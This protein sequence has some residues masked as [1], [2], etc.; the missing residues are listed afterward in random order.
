MIVSHKW[1]QTYFDKKLPEVEKLEEVLTLSA[2]EIENVKKVGDDYILDI[3]VLPNRAHD[4]LAH[5]GVARELAVLLE[6]DITFPNKELPEITKG[7]SISI[8]NEEQ[9]LCRRYVG[10]KVEGV[11]IG[12]SPDWLKERLETIGQKSINNIVDATNYVMFDIGQPLH[13]FDVDKV[14]GG[15]VVR[16]ARMGEKITTLDGNE[17]ELDESVLVIADEKDSLAIAGV[18]GGKKAEVDENTKNIILEAANF[19]PVNVRKTSRR[20]NILTDSSKRFENEITPELARQAMEKVTALISEIA[21]GGD[22]KI[23]E[24]V[25]VYPRKANQYKAGVSLDEINR[26]L[27]TQITKKEVENIWGRFEFDVE[28]IVPIEKIKKIINSEMVLDKKYESGAS[29]TYGAPLVFD[30]SS[31]SAW[32][33]KEAGIAIPRISVDQFVFSE[34]IKKDNLK[35]GDLVFSNTG[36][37]IKTGIYK[38]SVEFLPG[39][40][41]ESGVDHL[42]IYIGEGKILHTSSQTEKVVIEDLDEAKMFKNIVGYGRI[43]G[44]DKERFVVAIPDERLDLRIKEDLIEEIGR[45][46]GYKNIESKALEVAKEAPV[47]KTFYSFFRTESYCITANKITYGA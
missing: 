8:K 33:F 46:Y 29:V 7:E 20:L 19:A 26:L 24:I 6:M 40:K 2:F 13:A 35:F 3:D 28:D 21:G 43:A 10:R 36:F 41:V 1:L 5:R 31:L 11:K 9:D 17:V 32:I 42:G 22:V 39:T 44:V 14:E 47:N 45:V 4:C 12:P 37:V 16:K 27:G 34:R 30:C 23:G 25:D 38:E 15:I 18:K